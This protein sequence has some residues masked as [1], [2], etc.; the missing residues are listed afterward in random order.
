[1]LQKLQWHAYASKSLLSKFQAIWTSISTSMKRTNS[2]YNKSCESNL[3]LK[4]NIFYEHMAIVWINIIE[5]HHNKV[6]EQHFIFYHLY[7]IYKLIIQP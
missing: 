3:N 1:M 7:I 2:Y 6:M 4:L 5:Q